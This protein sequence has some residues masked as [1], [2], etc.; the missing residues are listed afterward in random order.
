MQVIPWYFHFMFVVM[1]VNII[2]IYNVI[3]CYFE[4]IWTNIT[5]LWIEIIN[6]L[7]TYENTP[8]NQY[9]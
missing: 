1:L 8:K 9:T 7:P 6:V 3:S 2:A 5:H 4:I